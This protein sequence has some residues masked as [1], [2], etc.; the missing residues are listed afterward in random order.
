MVGILRF[1]ITFLIKAPCLQGYAYHSG[2]IVKGNAPALTEKECL[3]Q[4]NMF[5]TC[6][7]WD[8]GGPNKICRLRSNEGMKGIEP[9][10]R[11]YG[12]QKNCRLGTVVSR[13]Y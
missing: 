10:A 7:F 6:T 2:T 1:T 12:G 4:C 9:D 11:Y 8:F 3:N 13:I 5:A